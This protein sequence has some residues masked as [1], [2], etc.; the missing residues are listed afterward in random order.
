[1]IG[2][3]LVKLVQEQELLHSIY[4]LYWYKSADTDAEGR[5]DSSHEA[6]DATQRAQRAAHA[7]A[8]HAGR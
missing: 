1:M 4:L 7:A 2:G 3:Q 6:S 5:A 8:P